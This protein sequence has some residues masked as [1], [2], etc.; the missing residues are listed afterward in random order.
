MRL[1]S[2]ECE[3]KKNSKAFNIYNENKITERHRHRYEF[4]NH[5]LSDFE[6]N[7]FIASGINKKLGLVEII[8]YK[9]HPWFIGVQ[10]HPEF[11]STVEKAQPLFVSFI[12]QSLKTNG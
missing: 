5:F 11:K 9:K 12:K 10:F 1:G 4:N 2:Y 6:K 8:E 7:H 3:I